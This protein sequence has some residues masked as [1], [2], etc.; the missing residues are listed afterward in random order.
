VTQG[1]ESGNRQ[2]PRKALSTGLFTPLLPKRHVFGAELSGFGKEAL[3]MMAA[4]KALLSAQITE[5]IALIR[6]FG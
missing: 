6:I 3:R 2:Q 5:I 1:P 4:A